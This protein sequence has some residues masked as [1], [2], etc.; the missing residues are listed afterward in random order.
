MK[1]LTM[2][3]IL[4]VLVL[5]VMAMPSADLPAAVV[6]GTHKIE[7]RGEPEL[8]SELSHMTKKEYYLKTGKI[9]NNRINRKYQRNFWGKGVEA[10]VRYPV[11]LA[12]WEEARAARAIAR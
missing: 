10:R 8:P 11:H 12:M 3:M 5:A 9:L 6:E 7:D 2:W 4:G 1:I